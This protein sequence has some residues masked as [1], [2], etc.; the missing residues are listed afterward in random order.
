MHC[1]E[2]GVFCCAIATRT[3]GQ[4]EKEDKAKDKGKKWNKE[5][6]A[7]TVYDQQPTDI[8]NVCNAYIP[9]CVCDVCV[10]MYAIL[11]CICVWICGIRISI[12][13]KSACIACVYLLMYIF[14]MDINVVCIVHLRRNSNEQ[15]AF[16]FSTSNSFYI[17][18]FSKQSSL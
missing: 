12:M 2:S 8:V 14:C 7:K 15:K 4:I 16:I 1:I 18:I 5:K 17:F 10:C 13:Y 3:T 11:T 6:V 9:T